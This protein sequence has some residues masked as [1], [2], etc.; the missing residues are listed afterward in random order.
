MCECGAITMNVGLPYHTN[1][2][3]I[4]YEYI[5]INAIILTD[6]IADLHVQISH[7]QQ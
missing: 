3:C 6:T 7:H 4:I 5:S 2:C 1:L